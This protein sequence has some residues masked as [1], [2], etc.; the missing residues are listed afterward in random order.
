MRVFTLGCS[1]WQLKR[2][3]HVDSICLLTDGAQQ[4]LQLLLQRTLALFGNP[5][6]L[7][8]QRVCVGGAWRAA[9]AHLLVMMTQDAWGALYASH[10]L[11]DY[12]LQGRVQQDPPQAAARMSAGSPTCK[13]P[14]L[15]A[16]PASPLCEPHLQTPLASPPNL[17]APSVSYTP[18]AGYTPLAHPNARFICIPQLHA[19]AS[20]RPTCM[21]HLQSRHTPN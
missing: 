17:Q 6:A 7:H 1:S 4:P 18:P 16:P 20:I 14:P 12:S 9:R 5:V 8:A 15:Q 21:H 19:T 2:P 13:P 11:L 10:S 3:I